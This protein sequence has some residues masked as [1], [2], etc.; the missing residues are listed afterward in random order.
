MLVLG[1]LGMCSFAK[2]ET[3][4]A[5]RRCKINGQDRWVVC[6]KE[7][8]NQKMCK[9][10]L[11][12]HG[13][14]IS[15]PCADTE[16]DVT[17]S[18]QTDEPLQEQ[19]YK[20]KAESNAEQLILNFIADPE[21]YNCEII[22]N[23]KPDTTLVAHEHCQGRVLLFE[24]LILQLSRIDKNPTFEQ[25][26]KIISIII[27]FSQQQAAETKVSIETM[28]QIDNDYQLKRK[29]IRNQHRSAFAKF[30]LNTIIKAMGLH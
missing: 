13:A 30:C 29:E 19:D 18:E 27:E 12:R 4:S 16:D 28:K 11:D 24:T 21:L 7:E 17:L 1:S 6:T 22:L 26:Q 8:A 25:M 2:A 23:G 10:G 14:V 5:V 9:D 15:S 20:F 3:I